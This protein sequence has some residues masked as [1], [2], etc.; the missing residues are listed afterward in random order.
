MATDSFAMHLGHKIDCSVILYLYCKDLLGIS[1]SATPKI[2]PKVG[3][4][5]H[6]TWACESWSSFQKRVSQTDPFHGDACESGETC[7]RDL[8]EH[9]RWE[10]ARRHILYMDNR[11]RDLPYVS[12][13]GKSLSISSSE[14]SSSMFTCRWCKWLIYLWEAIFAV[15]WSLPGALWQDLRG[16]IWYWK[17][18]A[19]HP[20]FQVMPSKRTRT[21]VSKTGLHSLLPIL[22]RITAVNKILFIHWKHLAPGCLTTIENWKFGH[23][24]QERLLHPGTGSRTV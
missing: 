14:S 3:I 20:D 21:M 2:S 5:L 11:C 24:Q 16:T 8:A 9:V 10:V 4:R 22:E 15:N 18:V 12:R 7:S 6:R 17:R 1:S 23:D 19:F 13:Y